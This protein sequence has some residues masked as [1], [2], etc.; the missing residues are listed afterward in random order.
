MCQQQQKQSSCTG[1]EPSVGG[2]LR[3][4][5]V[6]TDSSLP[7]ATGTLTDDDSVAIES[8]AVSSAAQSLG[9]AMSANAQS[10]MNNATFFRQCKT[11][12]ESIPR[13]H[14]RAVEY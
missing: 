8:N 7:G 5:V 12:R 2:T 1:L 3:V 13:K 14:Q 6:A 4:S 10:R 11:T 9:T